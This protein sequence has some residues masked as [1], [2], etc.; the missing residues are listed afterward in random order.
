MTERAPAS[1]SFRAHLLADTSIASLAAF[2]ILFGLLMMG[3][4]I[5]FVASGWVEELFVRPTFFFKYS[6]FEWMPVW[7]PTGLYVHM[8]IVAISALLV[9]LGLFYRASLL[10]FMLSFLGTLSEEFRS[11][12][13]DK[14]RECKHE[15]DQ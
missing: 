14:S 15:E 8:G 2:R 6:G 7:S 12:T 11:A 1:S 9:A 5:R 13:R 10:V 4:T 3:G